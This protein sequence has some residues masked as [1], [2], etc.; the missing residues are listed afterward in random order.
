MSCLQVLRCSGPWYRRCSKVRSTVH[1]PYMYA[2]QYSTKVAV[3]R[4]GAHSFRGTSGKSGEVCLSQSNLH[5]LLTP[6]AAASSLVRAA[7]PDDSKSCPKP[8]RPHGHDRLAAWLPAR[9]PG[10]LAATHLPSFCCV[11]VP[12]PPPSL[13]ESPE[14]WIF[15]VLPHTMLI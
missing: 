1:L 8:A 4:S 5:A 13:L 12:A 14:M 6:S 3:R 11:I 15:L 7:A 2:V 9:F 10:C